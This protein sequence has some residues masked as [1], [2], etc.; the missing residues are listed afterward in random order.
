MDVVDSSK[1]SEDNSDSDTLHGLPFDVCLPD[2]LFSSHL[3]L[4]CIKTTARQSGP[5][6]SI[7]RGHQK[8][9]SGINIQFRES[10][11]CHSD[12]NIFRKQ[13]NKA[14]NL[15]FFTF[16]RTQEN[17]SRY[18][19]MRK[20]TST[21]V[22]GRQDNKCGIENEVRIERQYTNSLENTGGKVAKGNCS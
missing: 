10:Y 16:L 8:R 17:G 5:L 20:Y 22:A 9:Q 12:H 21:E 6:R 13:T 14:T 11:Q 1:S 7:C 19:F 3:S 18:V 15:Y 4:V 2:S